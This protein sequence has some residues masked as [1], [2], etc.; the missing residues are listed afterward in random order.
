VAVIL[1]VVL[2]M[3]FIFVTVVF[4]V[5]IMIVYFIIGDP[6]LRLNRLLNL[7]YQKL[8]APLH[9]QIIGGLRTAL[10]LSGTRPDMSDADLLAK[11]EQMNV[12]FIALLGLI[13]ITIGF[14][15]SLFGW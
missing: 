10:R 5:P 2:I 15:L 3:V 7:A 13:I 9:G 8:L 11:V 6:L 12:P 4:F 14:I 1:L